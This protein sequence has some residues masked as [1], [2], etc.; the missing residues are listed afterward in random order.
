MEVIKMGADI[1]VEDKKGEE[2]FYFRDAYNLTNLAW[3]VGMSY[4]KDGKKNHKTFMKKLS[5]IT[6]EQ[7]KSRVNFLFTKKKDEIAK[8]ETK[9]GWIGMFKKK[10][11]NIKKNLAIIQD[12]RNKIIWSV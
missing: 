2:L 10:R 1:Y 11:N 9:R 4:W 7:I 12:K 8:G 6:D 3:V 5:E